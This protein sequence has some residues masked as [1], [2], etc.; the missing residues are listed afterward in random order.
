[1]TSH[2]DLLCAPSPAGLE[3]AKAAQ[4]GGYRAPYLG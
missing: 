4:I 1:M 2:H 3:T